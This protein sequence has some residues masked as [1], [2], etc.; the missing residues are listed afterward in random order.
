M[1]EREWA[2]NLKMLKKKNTTLFHNL[3]SEKTGQIRVDV[4]YITYNNLELMNGDKIDIN[5]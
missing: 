4:D 2:Q 3:K 5:L 1:L